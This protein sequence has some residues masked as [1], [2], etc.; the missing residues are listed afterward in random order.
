MDG[1]TSTTKTYLE[2]KIQDHGG[3]RKDPEEKLLGVPDVLR[4]RLGQL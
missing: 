2:K 3:E 1:R 4:R